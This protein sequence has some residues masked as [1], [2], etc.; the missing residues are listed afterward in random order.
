[1]SDRLKEM[2]L[3]QLNDQLEAVLSGEA[4]S[5]PNEGWI[6]AIRSA[7][8]MTLEQLAEKIGVSHATLHEYE[9]RE[10]KGTITLASLRKTAEA[11]NCDFVHAFVPRK[12]DFEDLRERQARLAAEKV[13]ERTSHSMALENQEVSERE[14][15]EEI[16]DLREEF[17][18]TW[19]NS[20]WDFEGE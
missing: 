1:M 19:D 4:D 10:A 18:S 7:L 8:G 20:I 3:R 9:K 14:K 5:L 13:V 11:L 2:V 17:L 6:R 12:G 16:E 15:E